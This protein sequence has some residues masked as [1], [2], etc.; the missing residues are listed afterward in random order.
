MAGCGDGTCRKKQLR[1]KEESFK[2]Q[3][4]LK[5]NTKERFSMKTPTIFFN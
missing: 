4:L 3:L 5:V 2:K 1:L